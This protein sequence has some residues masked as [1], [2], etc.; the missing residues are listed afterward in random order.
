V[1]IS[2]AAALVA[3]AAAAVLVAHVRAGEEVEV[4]VAAA[5]R[6]EGFPLYWVGERFEKWDLRTVELPGPSTYGFANLIYGECEVHDPD[7]PL[8]PEGGSC[9]PP[10]AIQVTPLCFHLDVVAR[11]PIWTRRSIRGA[12]VGSS[13]S[14]PVLFTRG[15]Q[16]KVYRGQGSDPGLALRALNALRSLNNVPPVIAAEGPIPGPDRA[17]LEGRRPCHDSRPGVVLIDENRGTY[18]GVGIGDTPREVRR[19]FGPRPFADLDRE[20]VFPTRARSWANVAGP[21]TITPPCRPTVPN[22][23]T[24]QSRAQ[25]LRYPEASFFFC[26]GRAYA[27]LAIDTTA[28]TTTGLRIGDPLADVDMLYPDITCGEATSGDAGRR[29]P[30]CVGALQ[31]RRRLWFGGDPI[32]SITISTTR[33]GVEDER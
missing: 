19:V 7:G 4:D 32:H 13:D 18:R 33:F 30:Y 10:L 22:P 21:S 9:A 2:V 26:D 23:R 25:I 24:G 3:G 6:F 16:I 17:V 8:S 15:A 14:A 1:A 20:P 31:P 5:Q 12:P 11:A 28:R 29:Y 27:V